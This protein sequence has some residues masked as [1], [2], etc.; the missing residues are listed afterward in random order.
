MLTNMNK[1]LCIFIRSLKNTSN[2]LY[3]QSYSTMH[4]YYLVDNSC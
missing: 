4:S 1:I 2:R 3:V